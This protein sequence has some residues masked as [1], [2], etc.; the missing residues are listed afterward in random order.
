MNRITDILDRL[1][2]GER[3]PARAQM[4][5]ASDS[6]TVREAPKDGETSI[7]VHVKAL[8][9]T[10]VENSALGRCVYDLS[11]C[12]MPAKLALDDSHGDEI[13]KWRPELTEFGIE[14]DGWVVENKANAQHASNRIAYNLRN[15]IPQEFSI[16]WRGP[17]D[18][19]IIAEGESAQVNGLDVAGPCFVIQNWLL[20]AGAI[21]KA[22]MYQETLTAA[23]LNAARELAPLPGKIATL[24][25]KPAQPKDTAMP[26][27]T[28]VVP[29]TASAPATPEQTSAA[30]TAP[31]APVADTKGSVQAPTASV[32]QQA[33]VDKKTILEACLAA[34]EKWG[35]ELG[36][37]AADFCR[38]AIGAIGQVN[39]AEELCEAG[40]YAAAAAREA[41]EEDT[42]E[43]VAVAHACMRVVAIVNDLVG[44]QMCHAKDKTIYVPKAQRQDPGTKVAAAPVVEA[45][46][47]E[48]VPQQAA[49]P[50]VET[51]APVAPPVVEAKVV[52]PQT[53][54]APAVDPQLAALQ[55]QNAQHV[56][57]IAD[58]EQRLQAMGGG[59]PP[60]PVAPVKP[61]PQIASFEDALKQVKRE[62]PDWQDH[63]QYCHARAQFKDVFENEQKKLAEA[64]K[65]RGFGRP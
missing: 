63:R 37:S 18:L 60:V 15:E 25:T 16:D 7:K 23:Q 54:A 49:A 52:T 19:A 2:K 39:E 57:K 58:L 34:L 11:T 53:A 4:A 56:T 32:P 62:H 36:K 41:G 35:N 33:A 24:G 30:P 9:R 27:T 31:V 50:K 46:M 51:P 6:L 21:C 61:A 42:P 12:R 43:A 45:P 40:F 22:G 48:T 8:P 13:G 44:W 59:A 65:G 55:Q 17:F 38:T 47:A 29:Q 5:F 3:L 26:D 1:Q 10:P 28:P 20:R 14:G 64:Q